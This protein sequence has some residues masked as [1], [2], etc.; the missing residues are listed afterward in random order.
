[1]FL[2]IYRYNNKMSKNHALDLGNC[3]KNLAVLKNL[4][5]KIK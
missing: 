4:V 2:Y 5:L 1:M 3:L